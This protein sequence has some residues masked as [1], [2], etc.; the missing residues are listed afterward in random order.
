MS[1]ILHT[2][3]PV[4]SILALGVLLGGRAGVQARTLSE[5]SLWVA[6]PAL[7]FSLLADNS[8]ALALMAV[9]AGG[10]VFVGLGTAAL[11]RVSSSTSGLRFC[12]MML[13]P[14][15]TLAGSWK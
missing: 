9:L 5:V 12:G 4:F 6:S 11:A 3:V 7:V 2:I 14:V 1:T 15:A 13:E 8:L 10:A